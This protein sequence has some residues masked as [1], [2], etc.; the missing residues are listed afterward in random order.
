[1]GTP[2]DEE[3]A[4]NLEALGTVCKSIGERLS[5][6]SLVMVRSTVPVGTTRSFVKGLLEKYSG[7]KAGEQ[8]NL[9]FTPE[10][11]VEGNAIRELT[12]LPQIIGGLTP[13]CA[14]RAS[15]F[16]QSIT[17]SVVQAEGLE[18]AELVKLINNSYRDLS[19]AFSNGLA[20]LADR[21]NL[22]ASKLVDAA[23]EG[24]PRNP[25]PRPSPGVGGYCL[26][27]DP[28]LYATVAK[29]GMHATLARAGRKANC[30]AAEYPLNLLERYSRQIKKP[31]NEL[32][33]LLVGIAFKGT[34]E[35]NDIRGST[36]IFIADR[37]NKVGSKVIGYDATIEDA[38]L[39]KYD[40]KA[41]ELLEGAGKCDVLMIL[42]NHPKNLASGLVAR[43]SSRPTL[44]FDGWSMLQREDIE[45][46]P[47]ITYA[48]MGYMT[49]RVDS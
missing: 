25:I 28:F 35:T 18:A 48:S 10:R 20:L 34:P 42:N 2:I 23:N 19:F 29:E 6:G 12:T 31:I 7:L 21:Y 4:A 30:D 49:S 17:H 22:Q 41:V 24:Y 36:A 32:V 3:G 39:K 27:K 45:R 16:W 14:E 5:R 37:L 43:L 26:T 47:N 40:I 8:F 9:A 46:H 13:R 1:V 11:T 33:V 38:E 44:L 15:M